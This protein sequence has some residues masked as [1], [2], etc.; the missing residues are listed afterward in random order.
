MTLQ[1][2][3]FNKPVLY[4]IL[5][6][7]K[8]DIVEDKDERLGCSGMHYWEILVLASVRLGCDLDYDALHDLAN[9][10]ATLRDIMQ[11]SRLDDQRFPRTTIHDNISKLSPKTIFKISDIIVRNGDEITSPSRRIDLGQ[12]CSISNHKS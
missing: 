3:Y 5:D 11:I 10:H 8:E 1:H 9:N 2:L 7:I 12:I 4:E 6:L